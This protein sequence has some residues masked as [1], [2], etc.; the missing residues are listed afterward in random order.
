MLSSLPESIAFAYEPIRQ[1]GEG[2]NGETWLLLHRVKKSQ[3]VLKFLKYLSAADFKSVELFQREAELLKSVSVEGVP[4]FYAYCTDADGN[5]FLLQEYIPYPSLQS[6]LDEGKV[7]AEREALEVALRI[8]YILVRLQDDYSPPI[9]HRDIKPSNVLYHRQ[10][11][12]V[13]LI[14]FGSV[15]NPQKRTGGSTIAGTFGYMPPEQMLGDV[16]IQSDYYALGATILHLITGVFPGDMP[17]QG[18]QLDIEKILRDKAPKTSPAV[19]GLLASLLSPDIERRPQTAKALC[20]AIQNAIDKPRPGILERFS[21]WIGERI[22]RFV[23]GHGVSIGKNGEIVIYSGELPALWMTSEGALRR[24]L[25]IRNND[26]SHLGNFE[27][28]PP[29]RYQLD[30]TFEARGKTWFGTVEVEEELL[31][32]EYRRRIGLKSGGGDAYR[33]VVFGNEGMMCKVVHHRFVPQS[34]AI[35]S[36]YMPKVPPGSGRAPTSD[37][38]RPQGATIGAP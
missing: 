29:S 13:W 1:I 19:R 31:P 14:D 37:P 16:A 34:N 8:A 4:E 20:D 17:S 38:S 22:V 11:K 28:L 24:V 6:L 2:A 33:S 26:V 35:Y 10:D 18:Y 21:R 3:A 23:G 32:W 12:A 27:H 36:V 7:F 30:Y 5:G 15:A 9:I 25:P